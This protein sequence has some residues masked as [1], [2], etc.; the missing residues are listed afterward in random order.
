MFRRIEE[1]L[2]RML[3]KGR[4]VKG[5]E[6]VKRFKETLGLE[7]LTEDEI[8]FYTKNLQVDDRAKLDIIEMIIEAKGF[9]TMLF[10]LCTE[11]EVRELI[12]M[13][14]KYLIKQDNP[15]IA[16]LLLSN[17]TSSLVDYDIEE[18]FEIVKRNFME[19]LDD[20]TAPVMEQLMSIIKPMVV[21]AC[22]NSREIVL[23]ND[24]TNGQEVVLQPRDIVAGLVD[25]FVGGNK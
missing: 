11:S 10:Q 15:G 17:K 4:I 20:E 21:R 24:N 7:E 25:I 1:R 5:S 6:E 23:Y 14:A 8:A 2:G 3:Y 18:V 13:I 19:G 22:I 9:D 16:D 12:V